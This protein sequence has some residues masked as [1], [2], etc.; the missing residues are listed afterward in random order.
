MRDIKFRAIFENKVWDVVGIS[1]ES[2]KVNLHATWIENPLIRQVKLSN[3]ILL[4]YTGL[5]DK[6]G[7]EIYEGDIIRNGYPLSDDSTDIAEIQF[8]RGGFMMH[9]KNYFGHRDI[10]RHDGDSEKH[11][12]IGNIYE[13]KELLDE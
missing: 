11:E 5:K 9:L 10:E 8:Y 12:V 7:V 13:D 6:N 4:Q 3:V 2:N 1:W